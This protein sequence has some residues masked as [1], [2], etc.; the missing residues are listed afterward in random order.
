M[1]TL[2][3]AVILVAAMAALAAGALAAAHSPPMLAPI[4]TS[5]SASN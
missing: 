2:G 3:V 5:T 4:R 1:F